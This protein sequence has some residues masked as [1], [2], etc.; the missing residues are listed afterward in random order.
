MEYDITSKILRDNKRRVSEVN[1]KETERE[2][3]LSLSA[4]TMTL[5]IGIIV[6]GLS[7]KL[8]A[9]IS[10]LI[11]IIFV[12]VVSLC[13]KNKW[14]DIQDKIVNTVSHTTPTLFI[15]LLVGILVGVWIVGGT[16]PSLICYGVSLISPHIIV[17]LT[18]ILCA[19]TSVFTGTS[20]GSIATMGVV[21]FSIGV[22]MGIPIGL[23]AGAVVSG[24]CFGDKMSPMSDT[25]NLAATMA[26]TDLYSHISSMLYTTLP[27][28]VVAII[29]YAVL[30]A[31]YGG[32]TAI[33]T[34]HVTLITETLTKN[35]NI[36]VITIIP[37][38]LLLTLSMKK[39]PAILAMGITTVVSAFTAIITQGIDLATISDA[40]LNGAKSNTGITT[41]DAILSRG[42]MISMFNTVI[43]ILFASALGSVLI[44]SGVIHSLVN[45]GL[46]KIIKTRQGL[47]FSTMAYC[48][49]LMLV[50]GNQSL[51]IILPGQTLGE[52]YDKLDVNR[53]V[54]SRTLEDT[55]TISGALIPW[56][57]FSLYIC[58]VLAIGTEYI[59]Y[60]FLNYIVPVFSIICALT[61]IGIWNS[62]GQ[63][64]RQKEI[65]TLVQEVSH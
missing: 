25:T 39:V 60:A 41:I 29:I 1:M 22:N 15:L 23:I 27:A 65:N 49:S 34:S 19:L 13:L 56:S 35:Y 45:N 58:G 3:S 57:P 31:K 7:F 51:G 21:L 5:V 12:V 24:S 28:T 63:K 30:G 61:G 46:V 6:L 52:T 2:I 53:K 11:A 38:I 33:D 62:A 48:Y 32:E 47:V 9:P 37:L 17:P 20:F 42:G 59:P 40:A 14:L 18:F 36:N 64:I 4:L 54:L 26:G 10:I 44:E 43:L 8:G 55:A 16:I 50:A